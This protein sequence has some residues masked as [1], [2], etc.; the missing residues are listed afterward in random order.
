MYNMMTIVY[1]TAYLKITKSR[2][3]KLSSLEQKDL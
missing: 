2:P 3:Q 1:C